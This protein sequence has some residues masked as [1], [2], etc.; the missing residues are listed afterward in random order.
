MYPQKTIYSVLVF[1]LI[2]FSCA[3]QTS[4]KPTSPPKEGDTT[5]TAPPLDETYSGKGSYAYAELPAGDTIKSFSTSWIVPS[6]PPRDS[7]IFWWNGLDG[8]A[9]QPVLQWENG[10]WTIANWYYNNGGYHHGTFVPITS[11]TLLTGVIELVSYT[12]DSF[13]YKESFVG[14]PAADVTFTRS[15]LA[16]SLV[17]CQ[18]AYTNTFLAFPADSVVRMTNID[19]ITTAGTHPSSLNWIPTSTGTTPTGHASFEVISS[20]SSDGEVDFFI[21]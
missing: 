15:T 13:T 5:V 21:K 1:A 3:K 7:T 11:G 6:T 10:A 4:V 20:S 8:G 18:E 16:T 12:T 19:C 17:E 9:L 2:L 14:Y